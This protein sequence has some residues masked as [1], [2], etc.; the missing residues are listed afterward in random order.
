MNKPFTQKTSIKEVIESPVLEPYGRLLFPVHTGCMSGHTLED[1][2]L[3]WYSHIDPQETIAIVNA[4]WERAR[5]KETV[6]YDIY[7]DAEKAADPRKKDTGLFFFKGRKG[8]PF[9]VVNAGGGFVYVGAMHDS[10]PHAYEL[11]KRGYN[12]FALIYRPGAQTACEDL[13][14]AISLIF[15]HAAELGVDTKHYFLWGGS[16]GATGKAGTMTTTPSD[17]TWYTQFRIGTYKNGAFTYNKDS[18]FPKG[19][20]ALNQ[21][22]RQMTPDTG[23]DNAAGEQAIDTDV[24]AKAVAAAIDEIYDR[25]GKKSILVTHSQGGGPGWE[26]VRCT[27]HVAAIVA[28][29]PGGAAAPGSAA[30]K[31][32]AEKKIPVTFYYGDYIGKDLPDIPA[33]AMWQRMAETADTFTAAYEKEGLTSTV[34]HLPKLGIKGNSHF[35]FEEANRDEIA[36]MIEEWIRKYAKG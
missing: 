32:L 36:A 29:E 20:A 11:S 35:M 19:E 25:T 8:A 12:A 28:I 9:A 27:P 13:A 16:A 30:Y 21:F 33:A 1:L 15:A 14:R 10:F 17:Q 2:Q 22:F 6:F 23:M 31:A 3:I 24:V 34:V 26:T 4:L 7:S 5:Q 18:K